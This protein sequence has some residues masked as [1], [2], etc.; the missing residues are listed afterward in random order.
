MLAASIT[1]SMVSFGFRLALGG[2]RSGR[3][4]L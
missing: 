3:A 4:A 2:I 1:I